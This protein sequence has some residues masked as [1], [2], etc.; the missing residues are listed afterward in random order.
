MLFIFQGPKPG[1]KKKRQQWEDYVDKG[2]G[3][4]ETDSFID[5][6]EAVNINFLVN[7]I[8]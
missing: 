3:Y 4:D 1:K 6:D 5:N 2:L 7:L 8:I